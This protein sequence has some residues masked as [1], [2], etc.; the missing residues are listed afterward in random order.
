MPTAHEVLPWLDQI[1]HNQW[2]TNNGPL[3]RKL[4][5]RLVDLVRHEFADPGIYGATVNSGT[6][7]LELAIQSMGLGSAI[8]VML[9]ALT[10]PATAT[11]VRRMGGRV[12]LTDVDPESWS[13]TPEVARATLEH[14][15]VDLVLP[16]CAFGRPQDVE[17][18]D[19]FVEETGIP[20]LIDAAAAFSSQAVGRHVVV[21]FSLHATKP[22]G[23]GEG[24]LV[25]SS[26]PEQI[27]RV[28][29]LTNFGFVD[30]T[31]REPASNGKLSEYHAAVGLAQLN[32]FAQIQVRRRRVWESY[33]TRFDKL[34]AWVTTQRVESEF[35]R[36]ILPVRILA[37]GGA[38]AVAE[39]LERS[40]VQTR[41]WYGPPLYEHVGFADAPCV[42]PGGEPHL[43]VT[44]DLAKSLLGLPFHS[45]LTEF[46]IGWICSLVRDETMEAKVIPLREDVA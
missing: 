20:V 27:E 33:R 46:E 26:S 39:R 13:L 22:F 35:I 19:A 1:D 43:P 23:I 6:A 18:W 36:S 37:P 45:F 41:R 11:A 30:G 2:Y 8:R 34:S 10:F 3:Q 28:R 40:N 15:D 21:T 12:V 42:G 25:L 24:G 7:A 14:T 17:K 4:E 5:E 9:P 29:W 16:V 44:A 38:Q 32:R 31:I